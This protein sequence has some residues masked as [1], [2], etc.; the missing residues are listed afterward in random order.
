MRFSKKSAASYP[1]SGA[2]GHMS[3]IFGDCFLA[4]AIRK[5]RRTDIALWGGKPNTFPGLPIW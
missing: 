1:D 5:L 2:G 4:E 3:V